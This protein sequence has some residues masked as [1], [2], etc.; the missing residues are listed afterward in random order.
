MN[1]YYAEMKC[2]LGLDSV[3]VKPEVDPSSLDEVMSELKE[4]SSP[5]NFMQ[6]MS[7]KSYLNKPTPWKKLARKV[8]SDR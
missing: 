1:D 8:L 7:V 6:F 4:N 3:N 2:E 5:A